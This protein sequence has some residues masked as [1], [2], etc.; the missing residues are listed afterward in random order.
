M[1]QDITVSFAPHIRQPLSTR[2]VM[3]DVLI[4]LIPLVVAAGFYFPRPRPDPHRRLRRLVHGDRMGLQLIR[5]KPGSLWD[6][7]AVV[8]GVI[9]A[10][11]LPPA[12][13]SGRPRSAR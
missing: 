10:L 11:S 9:L 2:R 3:L 8:T 5:K 7:S 13:P 12:L 1:P 4:G 6:L